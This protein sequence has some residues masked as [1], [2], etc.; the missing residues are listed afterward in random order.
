MSKHVA[1]L[2]LQLAPPLTSSGSVLL[3]FLVVLLLI[4]TMLLPVM[5]VGSSSEIVA[6]VLS[7]GG[8]HVCQPLR[9]PLPRW[10]EEP[11]P[12]ILE[13]ACWTTKAEG[14]CVG[15]GSSGAV[16]GLY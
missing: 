9:L 11:L 13:K 2:T 15:V 6:T 4:S 10:K 3:Q 7:R 14:G 1:K 12:F 8:A 16:V 5:P